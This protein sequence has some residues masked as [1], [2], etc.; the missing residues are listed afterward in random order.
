M[1]SNDSSRM[2]RFS[3]NKKVARELGSHDSNGITKIT[4]VS[5]VISI[6]LQSMNK[7]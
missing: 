1:N 3:L 4:L 5:H 2:N 7:C 6:H